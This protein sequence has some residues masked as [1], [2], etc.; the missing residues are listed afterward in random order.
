MSGNWL[1]GTEKRTSI[2]SIWNRAWR[3]V[4]A[5]TSENLTR[6][7]IPLT[8]DST[9]TVCIG[10]ATPLA[11]TTYGTDA[12]R[13]VVT[14]T[15]TFGCLG[16]SF[17]EQAADATIEI[18]AMHTLRKRVLIYCLELEVDGS[19]SNLRKRGMAYRRVLRVH[20]RR[21]RV[22]PVMCTTAS[23]T[24]PAVHARWRGRIVPSASR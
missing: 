20:R 5:W 21:G 12:R 7:R 18:A 9:A 8:C 13:T 6:C 1:C 19:P 17:F 4:T 16:G 24:G 15:G 14:L 3:V 2:G 11:V 10:S 22:A 23:E